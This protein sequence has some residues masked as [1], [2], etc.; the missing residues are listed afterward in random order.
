MNVKRFH[1][2]SL[3]REDTI[4]HHSANVAGIIMY[5]YYPEIP[6]GNLLAAALCHDVAERSTGD[7]PATAKWVSPELKKA[8][9]KMEVLL[10]EES[11]IHFPDYILSND[12]VN[13][14]K[15]ADSVELGLKCMHERSMGNRTVEDII[16]KIA[17]HAEDNL[18]NQPLDSRFRAK[19]EDLIAQLI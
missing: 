10:H 15:F 14:L 6:S 7:V 13:I 8:L 11:N 12:E 1:T 5:L 3:I 2:E 18:K 17:R 19:A 9:I 4:G 16:D